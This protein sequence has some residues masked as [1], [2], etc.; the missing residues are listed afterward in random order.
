MFRREALEHAHAPRMGTVL[1]ARPLS[2]ALLTWMFAGIAAAILAFFILAQVTRSA[3][4]SGVLLPARGLIRVQCRQPG[5]VLERHVEEG[6]RVRAGD[7]MFVLGGDTTSARY[8]EVAQTVATLLQVR[9][10]SL[11]QEQTRLRQQTAQRV[12]AAQRQADGL[13][14]ELE[15]LGEQRALQ[16]RRV[17]LAQA[18]LKRYGDLR[19]SGYVSV[20]QLQGQQADLLDQ[21]Q[22]LADLDRARTS[23]R[24]EL[25]AARATL[26][27]L[28]LQAERDL[29][30]GAREIAAMEQSLA[31]ND[32]RR[33]ILIRAP[34]DGTV[35]AITVEPGQ[36]AVVDKALASLLPAG[37]ELEAELYA[38]SRAAG[39][40]QPGM[41]VLLRYAAYPYQKFGQARGRVREVSAT[42]MPP[43][44]LT[45][46]R[47]SATEGMYRVRVALERQHITADG[48]EHPLS[49]G[50]A[51]HATVLL[52]R[53]RLYEW[54][55]EPLYSLRGSS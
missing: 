24:R 39:F 32:G 25:D 54:V 21:Q 17:E 12:E 28:P 23:T 55:L 13:A 16:Q 50:A 10:D 30:A 27:D 3:Q 46:A 19:E 49:A 1:L 45:P 41:P 34:Q 2:H 38:P 18:A 44:E 15:R 51:L 35:T 11:T 36:T 4:V 22:R 33:R 40:L 43:E 42:A 9:R 48:V 31:E 6:Q 52:E 29:Q 7:L 14:S 47:V 53:R 37:S 26:R 8:G 20:V 5:V